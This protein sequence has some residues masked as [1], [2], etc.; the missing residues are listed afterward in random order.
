M[1]RVLAYSGGKDSTALL[2]HLQEKKIEFTAI[3]CDTGW[4]HELTYK[5][6]DYINRKL[7][8]NKLVTIRSSVYSGMRDLVKKKTRVPSMLAR[9]CTS[10]LKVLPMINYVKNIN[11]DVL[12]YQGIRADESASRALLPKKQW[13]DDFDAYIERPLLHWSVQDCFDIIHRY[14]VKVNPLY[15]L[16]AKR[17]GCF[18]CVLIYHGELK[19]M[20]QIL[21]EIW[22]RIRDLEK[23]AGGKSFFPPNY[24][25]ERFRTGFDP[26]SGKTF[27]K[28]KDVKDYLATRPQKELTDGEGSTCM[29]IYNLCE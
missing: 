22:D 19:R 7:L 24:I 10:E 1:I 29:S 5:Y 23:A 6:L 26:K 16:G 21:P 3:F 11:D 15:K 28:W 18:P 13:S 20:T 14:K 17:V 27:P 25:P 4:E 2:L 12:V 9:F 8:K